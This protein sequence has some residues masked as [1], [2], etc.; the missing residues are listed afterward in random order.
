M[1][2]ENKIGDALD[3]EIVKHD[4]EVIH[5]PAAAAVAELPVVKSANTELE[6]DFQTARHNLTDIVTEGKKALK[7]VIDLATGTEHPRAYEVVGQLIGTLASANKDLLAVHDMK[8][9]IKRTQLAEPAS[10]PNVGEQTIN[11]NVFVGSTRELQEILS[12]RKL[13][14]I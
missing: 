10:T 3:I 13:K 14:V 6:T 2:Y 1:E 4:N 12:K 5:G 7:D 8:E 11:N 9:K